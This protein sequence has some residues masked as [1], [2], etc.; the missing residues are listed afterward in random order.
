MPDGTAPIPSR[1]VSRERSTLTYAVWDGRTEG[2]LLGGMLFQTTACVGEVTPPPGSERTAGFD[3]TAVSLSWPLPTDPES[4]VLS[5]FLCRDG[6]LLAELV[7]G[8][9]SVADTGWLDDH[10]HS[11]QMRP[12]NASFRESTGRDIW[13]MS[14]VHGD[15]DGDGTVTVLDIFYLISSL[16][17]GGPAPV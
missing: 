8:P 1:V 13:S 7:P 17:A 15:E 6:G 2:M 9:T 14:R 12:M 4:P 5:T 11:Y 16:L 10:F 3:G